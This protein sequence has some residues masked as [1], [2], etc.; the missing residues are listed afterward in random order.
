MKAR[1][2]IG[3]IVPRGIF[4]EAFLLLDASRSGCKEQT[5]P[6]SNYR[7]SQYV[8][9]WKWT[10]GANQGNAADI[11]R[12]GQ[13]L[14]CHSMLTIE[15][16]L[17]SSSTIPPWLIQWAG[18]K[19]RKTRQRLLRIE[20]LPVRIRHRRLLPVAFGIYFRLCRWC[21]ICSGY[22]EFISL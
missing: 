14:L 15:L 9:H 18:Q 8:E 11:E 21:P 10:V 3:C 4:I 1:N 12:A 6:F 13:H 16:L 19:G 2:Q 20:K 5:V 7:Q 17:S 22:T